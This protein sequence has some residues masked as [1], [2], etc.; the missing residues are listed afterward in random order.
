MAIIGKHFGDAG[1]QDLC[2][3]S[4][5]IV[6]VSIAGVS[7]RN[8]NRAII[9][10]ELLYET[11]IR[12]M[13]KQFPT[14]LENY[15]CDKREHLQSW[16]TTITVMSGD[17]SEKSFKDLMKSA[18]FYATNEAFLKFKEFLCKENGQLSYFWMSCVEMVEILLD[19]VRVS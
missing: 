13:W 12:L 19:M 17:L 16:I 3:E 15:D 1:L 5:L 7:C 14:L 6:G 18:S 10:H 11:L 9:L 8:Y 2:I 4:G